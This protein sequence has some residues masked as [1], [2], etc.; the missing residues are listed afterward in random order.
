MCKLIT[1]VDLQYLMEAAYLFHSTVYID[2]K[3]KVKEEL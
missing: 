1:G 2:N 3:V